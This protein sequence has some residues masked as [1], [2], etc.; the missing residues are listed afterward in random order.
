[1]SNRDWISSDV[2]RIS[3]PR[4]EDGSVSATATLS[5]T[6]IY[7]RCLPAFFPSASRSDFPGP[8]TVI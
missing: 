8:F 5:N 1:M 4:G 6:Y 3:M 7:V 2:F